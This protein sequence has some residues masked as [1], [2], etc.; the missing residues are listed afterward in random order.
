MKMQSN[1]S[2]RAWSALT[3][4]SFILA[5]FIA[6]V[7]LPSDALSRQKQ[8]LVLRVGETTTLYLGSIKNVQVGDES[9]I[10]VEQHPDRDKITVFP[11]GPGYSSLTMGTI[12]YDVVIL[13]EVAQ[14]RSDVEN[15]LDGI[16]GVSV[17]SA[18]NR[19]VIDGV[20]KRRDDWERIEAIVAA[21]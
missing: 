14:L 4:L 18:A 7:M 5:T 19:V 15:L 6:T 20:V 21:H 11:I 10:K 17:L 2:A 9:V 1:R 13:G 8:R 16:P 12:G 3:V